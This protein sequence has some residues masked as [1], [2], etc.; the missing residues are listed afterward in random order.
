MEF[1]RFNVTLAIHNANVNLKH[2]EEPHSSD[3]NRARQMKKQKNFF[4]A[5]TGNQKNAECSLL[6]AQPNPSA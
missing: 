3:K 5:T 6:N 4:V 2:L 1:I